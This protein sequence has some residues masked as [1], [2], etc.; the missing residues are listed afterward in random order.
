MITPPKE[1]EEQTLDEIDQVHDYE[2]AEENVS[3]QEGSEEIFD[4]RSNLQQNFIIA[5]LLMITV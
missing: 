5:M 1:V 3:R 2:E 4:D